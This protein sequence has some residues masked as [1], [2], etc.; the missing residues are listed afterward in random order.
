MANISSALAISRPR[1]WAA[2]AFARHQQHQAVI[3]AGRR[4]LSRQI[5]VERRPA[6]PEVAGDVYAPSDERVEEFA[7]PADAAALGGRDL[8]VLRHFESLRLEGDNI[9][10]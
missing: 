8:C 10:R 3:D 5:S 1:L 4:A 7:D 2:M 6:Y 9:Y